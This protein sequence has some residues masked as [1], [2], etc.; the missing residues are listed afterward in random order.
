MNSEIEVKYPAYA[1]LFLTAIS[2]LMYEILLTRIFSVTMWYHFAFMAISVVMFGMTLGAI[3][4]YLL[5]KHFSPERAKEQLAVSALLFAITIVI[6]FLIHLLI[7]F[8][9]RSSPLGWY[10]IPLTYI[11]IAV[12]F[13]FSGI[14]FCIA[15]T[16]FPRQVSRLYAV[17]LIGAA[18][19]CLLIIYTLKFTDGPTA[20][21]VVA[22]VAALGAL[23]FTIGLGKKRLL[24]TT[25]VVSVLL[26]SFA[27]YHT[28]LV[29]QQKP[30]IRLRWI[31]TQIDK[32]HLYEKW[33]SFSRIQVDETYDI[34]LGMGIS[35][36]YWRM[37]G[38]E[39]P[40]I[41]QLDLAIDAAASTT[42]TN[43][44]G[45]LDTVDYLKYDITNTAHYLR[46]DADVLV[47]G[48]GGGRDVLSALAFKQKSVVGVEINEDILKVVNE[49]YGDFT[50]HLDRI[51]G[52]TFVNDEAR[53]YVA[54]QDD[55]FDI[56]QVSLIDTW[57]ATAAGA[58]VLS[59]NSLY[60][61]EAWKMFLEKL[62]PA[63]ILTFT[64]WF[65]RDRPGE[66]YRLTS[67]A[68]ASLKELGIK[69][70]REHIIIVRQMF[71]A[72]GDLPE[73]IGTML[74]SRTP[75]SRKDIVTIKDKMKYLQFELVLTP[76]YALDENFA[77]IASGKDIQD[78]IDNFPINI[79]P[80]TDDSP[81][82]FNMLRLKDIF[83]K[84]RGE[85]GVATI[86]MRAV[87][88]LGILL[89]TVIVL[90][91]I[92][93]ILP[94]LIS[95]HNISFK[96][97]LPHFLFFA[98]IGIGFMLVEISQ[99][100][101]LIVFLGHPVYGLSVVL[102]ALLISSGLGSYFT[103]NIELPAMADKATRRMILLLGVLVIFGLITP[104]AI[105]AFASSVT[106]VRIQ[107]SIIILFPL[108]FFMGMAFPLGM[109]AASNMSNDITPW[110]WGINGATSVCASVFAV[111]IALSFSISASF[112][113]GFTFYVI[114]FFSFLRIC[115]S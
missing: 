43:F 63:G 91:L 22:F 3:I 96:Q 21:I 34:P 61:V 110:L 1:G 75:F 66:I 74:V 30:L 80:P 111:A 92:C 58:F 11:V 51:P 68:S 62:N 9:I 114:A 46:Q 106:L 67:L 94:L 50:G 98:S 32:P 12:P 102:F 107:I 101:R 77:T 87:F 44:N 82:F 40:R 39:L 60:T 76:D 88:I 42:I 108:G 97:A 53:S 37:Q 52:V 72:Q 16:K 112:W 78:F 35:T 49:K 25:V 45:D 105:R 19:G 36:A 14:C 79:A 15:L 109:R 38:T 95:S 64:R 113:T 48:V 54:R 28:A 90:T 89:I 70:P 4:V 69:N 20:V 24:L 99:M 26:F 115:R 17:D 5:P 85:Q 81:F 59:E 2:T 73:G 93:I 41:K 65:F 71:G 13:I 31:K 47:I 83:N 6:S 86:N 57:A 27:V 104:Y 55:S 103:H 10:S 33:N 23:F 8:G 18:L 84:E 7:P 56:I 100:Q 29:N